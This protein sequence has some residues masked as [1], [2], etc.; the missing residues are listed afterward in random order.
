[1]EVL[2]YI[3]QSNKTSFISD[4]FSIRKVTFFI[5]NGIKMVIKESLLSRRF[6]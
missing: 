6:L 5:G 4:F 2:N 3:F 1:M